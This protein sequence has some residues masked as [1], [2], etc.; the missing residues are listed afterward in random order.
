MKNKKIYYSVLVVLLLVLVVSTTYAFFAPQNGG[1]TS[2]NAIVTSNTTDLLTFSINRDISFTVTQALFAENGENQSGDATATAT[3]T[4]NNKT[5]AATMNYYLYLNIESNPT[6]YSAANTNEDPELMLQVF[7]GNNQLVTL[8]GL[9][10]Q[11][12]IKGVTG[13]D[14]TGVEGLQT[15]LDNHEISATNNTATIENWRVVITLI[16]LD[17][18]QNDNTGKE[19]SAEII[20]QKEELVIPLSGYIYRNNIYGIY[21]GDSIEDSTKNVWCTINDGNNGCEGSTDREFYLTSTECQNHISGTKTCEAGTINTKLGQYTINSQNIRLQTSY[22]LRHDI[23][24]DEIN[25]SYAC[26]YYNN[27]EYCLTSNYWLTDSVTTKNTL[28]NEMEITLGTSATSCTT[29]TDVATCIFGNYYCSAFSDNSVECG[30]TIDKLSCYVWEDNY[31]SCGSMRYYDR[32]NTTIVYG[33]M[34]NSSLYE[35][36]GVEYYFLETTDGFNVQLSSLSECLEYKQNNPD[37]YIGE[38]SNVVPIGINLSDLYDKLEEQNPGSYNYYMKLTYVDNVLYDLASCVYY[39]YNGMCFD[40]DYFDTDSATTKA[41]LESDLASINITPIRYITTT[42]QVDACFTDNCY[43]GI[44]VEPMGS[45]ITY[46]GCGCFNNNI[47]GT[48]SCW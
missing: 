13:Y 11:K 36:I 28:Q 4:P 23:E 38:C 21:A 2:S 48:C 43:S 27:H 29:D 47:E 32:N 18:N 42:D 20:I 8:T 22:Y 37:Y 14:I 10:T 3:L 15:L 30:N 6:V 12:T 40:T 16:N 9:G 33:Y 35:T 39:N 44:D 46:A 25:D 1:T 41:K 45:N 26:L 19:I 31:S 5:G 7:D 24:D 34:D 17:V